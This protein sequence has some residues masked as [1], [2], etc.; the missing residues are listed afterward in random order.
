MPASIRGSNDNVLNDED[1]EE[2]QRKQNT[3]QAACCLVLA[4][5][6]KVLAVSRRDDPNAWGMP[7]GKVDP[8]EEP[9]EAAARELK[10]ETGLDA[11][12]LHQVFVKQ[13][14]DGFVTYTFA[15]EVEGQINTEES[16]VIRWVHPSVLTDPTVSPFTDYNVELFKRLGLPMK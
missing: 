10:E 4:D 8:G 6:G 9:M 1:D 7:G 12:R 11:T 14:A 13:D 2:Q 3:K 15:C 5:D 16:G